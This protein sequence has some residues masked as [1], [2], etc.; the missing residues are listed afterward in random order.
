MLFLDEPTAGV[1]IELRS[2]LWEFVEE[3]R[4]EG[5]S[6]LLTT[7][8][9]EEAEELCDRVG[10]LQQGHLRRVGV[11]KELIATATQ[12]RVNITSKL[13]LEHP[14]IMNT[15]GETYGFLLPSGKGVGELLK[16]LN[17]PADKLVD[18]QIDEGSL[19]DAFI[20]GNQNLELIEYELYQIHLQSFATHYMAVVLSGNFA[21]S[22]KNKLQ[23][24]IFN[25]YNRFMAMNVDLVFETK[26]AKKSIVQ[27]SKPQ[28]E[29]E[30]AKYFGN[31]K[32]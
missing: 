23:D 20:Q 30:L 13:R 22:A 28:I 24:V 11:T 29:R 16:E 4:K 25:F 14:Q 6:I 21:L 5:M 26:N 27:A 19:E 15:S 10:I 2:S 8:Y 17:I 1:D 18:I 32:I 9:L 3:L 7:H 12:R 31:A